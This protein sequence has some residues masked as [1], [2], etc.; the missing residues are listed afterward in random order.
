MV[1]IIAA[2]DVYDALLSPRPYRTTP[3]DNR[4]ALE[5]I[6][7]MAKGGKLSW[8]VVQT[9]VSHNRKDRPHFRECR[10]STE[11]R[12]IPPP[13]NLYGVIIEKEIKCPS[14]HGSCIKEKIYKEYKEGVEHICYECPNCGK[15]FDKDDL[16]N[17]EMDKH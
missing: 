1:E 2:C 17:I 4:T 3:Y 8:D 11:K 5:E 12:G 15:E 13:D 14:C 16:L 6:T 7:E 9:L 10:I